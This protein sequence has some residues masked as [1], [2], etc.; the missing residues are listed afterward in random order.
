LTVPTSA[1]DRVDPVP[2]RGDRSDRAPLFVG[3]KPRQTRQH[4]RDVFVRENAGAPVAAVL[5]V[6]D[7]P[8][9]GA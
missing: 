4:S 7:D 3:Q 9:L 5:G 1:L 2:R 6:L 8:L